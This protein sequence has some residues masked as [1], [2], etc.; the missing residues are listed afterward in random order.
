VRDNVSRSGNDLVTEL[1]QK[2][3]EVDLELSPPPWWWLAT[4][5]QYLFA[6]SAAIGAIW[7]LLLGVAALVNNDFVEPVSVLGLPLPFLM[8]VLGLLCG[9]LVTALS[10]WMLVVGARRRRLSAQERLNN[11]VQLLADERVMT[12]IRV[13]LDQHR[14]TRLALIG[15]HAE[16]VSRDRAGAVRSRSAVS[17]PVGASPG[18]ASASAAAGG[19]VDGRGRSDGVTAPGVARGSADESGPDAVSRRLA[20]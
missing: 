2:V 11:A 16:P 8:L 7:L 3:S 12:P 5:V 19:G 17:A 6:L 15:R 13:V 14:L 20:V 18:S 4:V 1:D 9:A 10:A